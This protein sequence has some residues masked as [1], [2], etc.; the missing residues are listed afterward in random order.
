MNCEGVPHSEQKPEIQQSIVFSE[1]EQKVL[2]RFWP[3]GSSSPMKQKQIQS[4]KSG[5]N[6]D[7]DEALE[8]L[9][10]KGF[11]TISSE[12]VTLNHAKIGEIWNGLKKG[13]K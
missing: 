13:M 10:K 7:C 12:L 9:R 1:S 4:I 5:G 2:K 8:S 11:L 3:D 6:Y